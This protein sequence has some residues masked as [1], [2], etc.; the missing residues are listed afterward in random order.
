[1]P[2]FEIRGL[3]HFFG[4]LK[5]VSDFNLT[6][7]GG[8]LT[9]LIGPNGAGKTTIFNL[10]CGVYHPT[11]GEVKIGGQNLSGLFPHQVTAKGIART[12]Q[13]IRLWP[14]M[15]VL[16]NIRVA[17]NYKLS[18]GFLDAMFQTFR[19]RTAENGIDQ[20]AREVLEIMGLRD[21]GE[22]LAKNLPY[23]LQRKVEIARALVIRPKLLLLDEPSAGMN[24]GEKEALIGLIRWIRKEFNLTIWLIEH[25]MRVVMNLCE[26]IQVLDFG[27]TIA[28]GTPEE[29]QGNPRVVE[30]YLG[31]EID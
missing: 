9:G 18:Y 15:T 23:G 24:L 6:F 28:R 4:G 7:E 17:H 19:Y 22:E 11:Q 12:F 1:M 25:E 27:E 5:A 16:D 2:L 26:K 30:A 13:N 3:T 10:V 31:K 8:E 29:I 20:K 21:Y 14:E